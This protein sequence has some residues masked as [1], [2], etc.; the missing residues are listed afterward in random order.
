MRSPTWRSRRMATRSV[1]GW[2]DRGSPSSWYT[3]SRARPARGPGMSRALRSL[4]ESTSLTCRASGRCVTC[5]AGSC[6]PGPHHGCGLDGGRGLEAGASGRLLD[7]RLRLPPARS[8]RARGRAPPRPGQP[9]RA[10]PTGRYPLGYLVPL[11]RAA[12]YLRLRFL[13]ALAYDALRMGPTTLWRAR[14]RH[15]SSWSSLTF[16]PDRS[17]F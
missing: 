12:R 16:A 15:L 2:R 1:T 9:H 8:E 7:G 6:S 5:A 17:A 4:T 10:L 3:G 11:L 14:D 13:P